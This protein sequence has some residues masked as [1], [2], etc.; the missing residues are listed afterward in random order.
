MTSASVLP[1]LRWDIFC[2]VIDNHGDLGVSWRL[3]A[4]LAARGDAV[5]LWADDASALSWMAPGAL[6]NQVP[7]IQVL[8]WT[9]PLALA[10]TLARAD[11]WVETF[12]CG[13]PPEFIAA[14]RAAPPAATPSRPPVWINLEYLSAQA[15]VARCHGLPSP[16]LHGPGEGMTRYFFYPGFTPDTGG[17]LREADLTERQSSFDAAAWLRA[18][19]LG[20]DLAQRISLFCYEPPALGPWL[21]GLVRPNRSAGPARLLVTP[22]RA[23][24]AV[25]THIS[26]KNGIISA[27]NGDCSLHIS[28]LPALPQTDFDHLLWACDLNFVRGEDSLVRALWAG[29]PFVWHIYP[30]SDGAHAAKLEAFL[31]WLQAPASLRQFHRVWNGTAPPGTPL[32]EPDLPAW[33][34]CVR[35][36]RA[37]LLA[38]EDLLAR[39]LQF[40]AKKR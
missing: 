11:V 37:R 32:P 35:A 5:R 14:Q 13:I 21:D 7:G 12:G 9:Q 40:I 6:A 19:H 16:V 22:G 17:L 2:Q 8:P 28:Y 27:P 26:S 23:A 34:A 33:G 20:N 30:Q 36:A 10:D 25:Q 38:Q 1:P 31:D 3:A 29:R 18:H 24:R 15:Y 39:L 4:Q